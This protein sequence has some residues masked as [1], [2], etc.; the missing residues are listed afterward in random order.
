MPGNPTAVWAGYVI[1]PS[2]QK[3]VAGG[4]GEGYFKVPAI[5]VIIDIHSS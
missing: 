2:S 3:G 1:T 5:L 4:L